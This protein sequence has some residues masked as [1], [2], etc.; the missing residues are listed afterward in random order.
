M[1]TTPRKETLRLV[2][3]G[4]VQGVFFRDSM[5]REA[6]RLAVRG[7]VRNR[8]DGTVEAVVQG[9]PAAVEAIVRWA[10]RGPEHARVERVESE[11]SEG[12]YSDFEILY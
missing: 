5:R 3:H 12:N 6:Q 11:P 7:W 1:T 4:R 9:E 10:H 2:V 8:S